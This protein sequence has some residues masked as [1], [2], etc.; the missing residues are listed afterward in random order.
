MGGIG[1]GLELAA[2]LASIAEFLLKSELSPEAK[3][4]RLNVALATINAR[5]ESERARQEADNQRV[6][7]APDQSGEDLADDLSR[8]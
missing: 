5:V 1:A 6:D 4:S 7:A 2:S 3:L 8:R